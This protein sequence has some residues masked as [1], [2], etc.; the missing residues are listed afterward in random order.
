MS[1]LSRKRIADAE[2]VM[3]TWFDEG[4][5]NEQLF[6]LIVTKDGGA[7][8]L[9]LP[10]DVTKGTRDYVQA[11]FDELGPEDEFLKVLRKHFVDNRD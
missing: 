4:A 11:I 10:P 8:S 5:T 3:D 7:E 2:V 6:Q 9:K 1:E